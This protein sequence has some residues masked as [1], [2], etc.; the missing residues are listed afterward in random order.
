MVLP[1]TIMSEIIKI[2]EDAIKIVLG[3]K[4][5]D[6]SVCYSKYSGRLTSINIHHRHRFVIHTV[7]GDRITCFFDKELFPEVKE[8][9]G[10]YVHV[11]G[12]AKYKR[13]DCIPSEIKV[14]RIEK[15]QEPNEKVSLKDLYGL[16]PGIT[17]GK[18]AVAFVRE[19]R[20]SEG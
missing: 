9:L 6:N 11:M 1:A 18:G 5:K 12:L 17:K 15:H 14:Q 8:L 13:D 16:A 19:M 10:E 20:Y 7:I 3:D 4:Y 2:Q